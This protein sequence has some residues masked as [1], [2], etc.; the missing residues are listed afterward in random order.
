MSSSHRPDRSASDEQR[1]ALKTSCTKHPR[2]GSRLEIYTESTQDKHKV[3]DNEPGCTVAPQFQCLSK[4]II[5]A[6]AH[7]QL[8]Q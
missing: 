2:S 8:K 1:Q 5:G 4:D 3:Q 7:R 6:G